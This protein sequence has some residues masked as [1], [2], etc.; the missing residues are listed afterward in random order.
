MAGMQVQPQ[1]QSHHGRGHRQ[2]QDSKNAVFTVGEQ[3]M[4]QYGPNVGRSI[5]NWAKNTDKLE[6]DL[7]ASV[8]TY[9]CR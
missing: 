2:Q 6:L 5:A 1:Q 8:I 4:L 9:I 3:D 7:I